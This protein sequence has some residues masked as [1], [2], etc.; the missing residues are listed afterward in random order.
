MVLAYGD[1]VQEVSAKKGSSS[2]CRVSRRKSSTCSWS[3]LGRVAKESEVSQS[4]ALNYLK[5]P[6]QVCGGNQHQ[7][8]Q[9]AKVANDPFL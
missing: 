7:E 1:R 5:A 6:L 2:S 3:T 9:A 4:L 8:V